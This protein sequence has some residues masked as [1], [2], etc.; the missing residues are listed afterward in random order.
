VIEA[1]H[2]QRSEVSATFEGRDVF[3]PAAAWLARGT[4]PERFGS[5]VD[6]PVRLPRFA[7]RLEPGATVQVPVVWIDRF[8]SLVLDVHRDHLVPHLSAGATLLARAE[9]LEIAPLARTYGEAPPGR[10]SLLFGSSGYL[11]VAVPG[12]RA[13]VLL[14][15]VRGDTVSLTLEVL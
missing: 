4:A 1:R 11:E 15:R 7:A 10:A 14:S 2:Y 12:G 9:E 13:D 3:A 6:D 5:Q 8:G